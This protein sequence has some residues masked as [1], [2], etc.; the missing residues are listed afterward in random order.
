MRSVILMTLVVFLAACGGR[1]PAPPLAGPS[2]APVYETAERVALIAA[3]VESDWTGLGTEAASLLSQYI[4][5][6]TTNPPGNEIVAARWLASVLDR[7]STR[8][9]SSHLGNSY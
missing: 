6:N 1:R 3:P 4:R 5:I 2:T 9:N 8:L 7:K